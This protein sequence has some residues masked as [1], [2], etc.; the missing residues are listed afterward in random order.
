MRGTRQRFTGKVT[1]MPRF[2]TEKSEPGG[3]GAAG[4]NTSSDE[5]ARLLSVLRFVRVFGCSITLLLSAATYFSDKGDDKEPPVP[6]PGAPYFDFKQQR[7]LIKGSHSIL[8]SKPIVIGTVRQVLVDRFIVDST[9]NCFRRV[10]KPE[11]YP[12]N[13]VIK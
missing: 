11:K 3:V 2:R 12:G 9:W 5:R 6:L 7:G 13:P 4:G 1:S 8:P 10:H